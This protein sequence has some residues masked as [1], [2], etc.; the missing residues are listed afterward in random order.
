MVLNFECSKL[1]FYKAEL[2]C[3]KIVYIFTNVVP[4]SLRTIFKQEWDYRYKTSLGEWEDTPKKG[5]KEGGR[6][7]GREGRE[8]REGGRKGGRVSE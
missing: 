8:G 3:L 2:R 6:E 7:G 4:L 5:R 1:P